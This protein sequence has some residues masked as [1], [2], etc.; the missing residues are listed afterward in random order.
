MRGFSE[1]ISSFL[2][3][4]TPRVGE[5]SL[6]HEY[7][8]IRKAREGGAENLVRDLEWFK[9]LKKLTFVV[10]ELPYENIEYER[11][12]RRTREARVEADLRDDE[13]KRQKLV[14]EKD[15]RNA[16]QEFF[17]GP[18]YWRRKVPEVDYR[19]EVSKA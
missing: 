11:K 2:E 8:G 10:S 9:V 16:F 6:G 14:A 17:A 5:I 3:F 4:R 18:M 1:S 13:W 7:P 15:V 12:V 19:L